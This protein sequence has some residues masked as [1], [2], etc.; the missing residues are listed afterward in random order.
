MMR[1]HRLAWGVGLWCLALPALCADPR[2][3]PDT[4][5][6]LIRELQTLA[7]R[8]GEVKDLD[9]GFRQ[10]KHT[11]LLKE[12]LVSSGRV[13]MI[14]SHSR[15]DT[16][17]PY[18]SITTIDDGELRVYDPEENVVEVYPL[19]R[20]LR[21][22]ALSPRPR[23]DDL[24]E[25]FHL[26]RHADPEAHDAP[27]TDDDAGPLAIRLTPRAAQT[28]ERVRQITV[29][30]DRETGLAS[31]I[32]WTDADDELTRLTFLKPRINLGLKPQTVRFDPP[33]DATVIF[34]LG[35]AV[36]DEA[37]PPVDPGAGDA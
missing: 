2:P 37:D 18:R 14:G 21:Q 8:A 24:L 1:S 3:E 13:R 5:P 17:K 26:H 23:I 22:I 25:H 10:E 11:A 32:A 35:G 15:W 29:L 28:A 20:Q 12:P 7:Q 19:N 6:A 4:D 31:E 27:A 33:A 16:D 36:G 30:I 9:A 34:P